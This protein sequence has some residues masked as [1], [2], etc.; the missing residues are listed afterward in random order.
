MFYCVTTPG[1]RM[2][3][4]KVALRIMND[5]YKW[6]ILAELWPNFDE[7]QVDHPCPNG[8]ARVDRNEFN[9]NISQ[10]DISALSASRTRGYVG[11][12]SKERYEALRISTEPT[13]EDL[14]KLKIL[15]RRREDNARCKN[16]YRGRH[17]LGPDGIARRASFQ[18][19]V[20]GLHETDILCPLTGCTAEDLTR[21]GQVELN[22]KA[23]EPYMRPPY[24]C[25]EDMAWYE[26]TLNSFTE[27]TH[28]LLPLYTR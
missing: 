3:E 15:E 17:L 26:A 1:I 6:P 10:T 22:I 8:P 23:I 25:P 5:G 9:Y 21:L 12:V 11:L 16:Y 19:F 13:K 2:C 7:W 4:Y 14:L 18:A 20:D 27:A 28:S 24:S